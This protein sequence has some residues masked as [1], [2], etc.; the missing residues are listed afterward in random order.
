MKRQYRLS[1]ASWSASTGCAAFLIVLMSCVVS[2]AG[3]GRHQDDFAFPREPARL[4]TATTLGLATSGT[5]APENR[6][7]AGERFIEFRGEVAYMPGNTVITYGRLGPDG[8]P[9]PGYKVIAWQADYG[10]FGLILGSFIPVKSYIGSY[11]WDDVVPPMARY[12]V[13]VND[14]QFAAFQAYVE[15][16]RNSGKNFY[17][18]T[19]NCV[20]FVRGAA[21][22]IGLKAPEETFVFSPVYVNMLRIMN[23]G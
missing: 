17:L 22:A 19:D 18:Y 12:R 4:E 15:R 11:P 5:S 2:F 13:R 23:G 10:A 8:E 3:M 20:R 6:N 16:E 1:F 14:K 7:H 9:A 21:R